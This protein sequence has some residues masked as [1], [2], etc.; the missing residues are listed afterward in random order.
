[1]NCKIYTFA[2]VIFSIEHIIVILNNKYTF[3]SIE[4]YLRELEYNRQIDDQGNKIQ[5]Y[6]STKLESVEKKN[7]LIANK[8]L[9]IN[10]FLNKY[11]KQ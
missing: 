5:K 9:N 1:M 11:M 6:F 10:S 8:Y 7:S 4:L 3:H 2:Y